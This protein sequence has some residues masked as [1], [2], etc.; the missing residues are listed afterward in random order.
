MWETEEGHNWDISFSNIPSL[1]QGEDVVQVDTG[2]DEVL[3]LT[4]EDLQS[5]IEVLS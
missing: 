2:G 3:Y 1:A 4:L 5:M